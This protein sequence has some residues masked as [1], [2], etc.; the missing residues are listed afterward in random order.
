MPSPWFGRLPRQPPP[1]LQWHAGRSGGSRSGRRVAPRPAPQPSRPV[2]HAFHSGSGT[3]PRMAPSVHMRRACARRRRPAGPHGR[4]LVSSFDR[5]AFLALACYRLLPSQSPNASSRVLSSP[6][7]AHR[8]GA[9]S[10]WG[11]GGNHLGRCALRALV[12]ELV[13]E[14]CGPSPYRFAMPPQRV[15]GPRLIAHSRSER[16][17]NRAEKPLALQSGPFPRG[18]PW[19]FA[20]NAGVSPV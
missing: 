15:V 3:G 19:T 2:D 1:G 18:R 5:S 11:D 12:E 16:Q 6:R 8:P 20:R 13:S 10:R 9:V 7:K 4:P 17:P 14:V